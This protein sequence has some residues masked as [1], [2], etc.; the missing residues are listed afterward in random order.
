MPSIPTRNKNSIFLRN[1]TLFFFVR[2]KYPYK[3]MSDIVDTPVSIST[4]VTTGNETVTLVNDVKKY[5]TEG[6]VSFLKSQ[7]LGLS[8]TAINILEEEEINGLNFLDITEE[9]LRS[10]GMKGGPAM[11]LAKFAKECKDKKLR[12]FSS[13]KTKKELGKV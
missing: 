2:A 6:L 10:Y 13:Y 9:K 3:A 11:T 12:P 8:E 4:S 1:V 7:N 5:D